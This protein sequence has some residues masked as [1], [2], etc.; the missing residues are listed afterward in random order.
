MCVMTAHMTTG[1]S[2]VTNFS[3]NGTQG[4]SATVGGREP[5]KPNRNWVVC[6]SCLAGVLSWEKLAEWLWGR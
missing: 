6:T 4:G 3:Q 5:T 1:A 2:I